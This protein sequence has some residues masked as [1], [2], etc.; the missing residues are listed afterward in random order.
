MHLFATIDVV[1]ESSFETHA[2]G[3]PNIG[4]VNPGIESEISEDVLIVFQRIVLQHGCFYHLPIVIG[5]LSDGHSHWS[6]RN[7]ASSEVMS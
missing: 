2:D 6:K 3:V 1:L 5:E 4:A 7:M